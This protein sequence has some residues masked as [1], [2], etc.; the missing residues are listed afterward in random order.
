MFELVD[1]VGMATF[2]RNVVF[3]RTSFSFGFQA[4]SEWAV[5]ISCLAS[6]AFKIELISDH[7]CLGIIYW[8]QR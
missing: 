5:L 1:T 3:H 7:R 2:P 8:L 6:D 4:R